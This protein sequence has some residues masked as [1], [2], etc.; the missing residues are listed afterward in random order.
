LSLLYDVYFAGTKVGVEGSAI[1]FGYDNPHRV[2]GRR[3][4]GGERD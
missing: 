4:A 1:R 3:G 2:G